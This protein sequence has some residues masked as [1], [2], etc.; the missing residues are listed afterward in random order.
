MRAPFFKIPIPS[1]ILRL[2]FS[3]LF[4]L[5]LAGYGQ[6]G[7]K[8]SVKLKMAIEDGNL[9]HA[10]ITIT[11][12]GKPDRVIDPSKGK[13]NI[14]LDLGAEYTLAFTKMGYIS[15]TVI[16]DT[17]VPNGREDAEFGKFSATVELAKQPEDQVITYSQPVGR[18]KYSTQLG[19]FDYDKDYTATA[20][21]M[22]KKA[23]SNPAP[24]PKTPPPPPP[25]SKPIPVEVKQPEYKPEP[26]KPKPVVTA[27][28]APV[29]PI[30][31]N[32]VEKAIQEDRRKITV[33][34]VTIDGV[35]HVYR[36]EQYAW[37]GLYYYKDGRNITE[38][39]FD[40][41]TE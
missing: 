38:S 25:V 16:I 9:E 21:A 31:K 13:Y 3:L 10:L 12:N 18:I 28:E 6:E 2:A 24:K 17:H 1:N 22:I 33:I 29:K 19:D 8:F 26:P 40:K 35:D 32:K 27:T 41:E 34:T 20:E 39:T 4:M 37:G 23:E 15:K 30:V 14:D 7:P 5:S 11:K 36:R